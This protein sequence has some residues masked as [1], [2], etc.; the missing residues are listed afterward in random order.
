MNAYERIGRKLQ[1]AREE[2]GMSQE[3]LAGRLGCSQAS[4]SYYELGKRRIYFAELEKICAILKRP[5]T[6]FLENQDPGENRGNNL[7]A[8]LQEPHM[9]DILLQ[10]GG[11]TP[12]Q[13]KSVLEYIEWRKF[14]DGGKK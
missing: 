8:L 14:R 5:L 2:A 4:L 12:S 13:R 1:K 11:L 6:Y 10:A 7:A 3:E 9:E